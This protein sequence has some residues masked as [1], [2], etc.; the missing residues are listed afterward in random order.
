MR[1]PPGRR[2]PGPPRRARSF[3]S[4]PR[5][6]MDS[7][8]FRQ[9]SRRRP[10]PPLSARR[11][12]LRDTRSSLPPASQPLEPFPSPLRNVR[13][14]NVRGRIDP[15]SDHIRFRKEPKERRPFLRRHL[16]VP[17]GVEG[18]DPSAPPP[19]D[20]RHG[21]EQDDRHRRASAED[22]EMRDNRADHHDRQQQ[23]AEERRLR[24]EEEDRPDHL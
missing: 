7:P 11:R 15:E 22:K 16:F 21:E 17:S 5:G 8:P 14:E 2:S 24:N 1:S 13:I 6:T 23:R 18:R 4:R 3:R 12:P 10:A 9:Y 20:D 19:C